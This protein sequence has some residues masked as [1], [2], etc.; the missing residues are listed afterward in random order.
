MV[1]TIAAQV[2]NQIILASE[3]YELSGPIE[4]RIRAAGLP[5][6]EI[7]RVRREALDRLIEGELLSSVVERLELTADREEVDTAIEAI[8]QENGITLEQLINSVQTHG[9]TLDEYRAKI[10]GEI[11]R[12][13]VVN[14]MV[15]SRIQI[16][17]E[18]IEAL[19]KERFSDQRSGGEEILLRHILVMADGPEKRSVADA[20][21]IAAAARTEIVTG[22]ETFPEVARDVSDMNPE[23]GGDLGWMHRKDLA[24]WMAQTVE[25]MQPGEISEVIEMPFGCNLLEVVERR[26]FQPVSFE[27][28][29]PQ[30]QNIIF[31]RKTEAEY[32]KWLDVLR[33]Q[34]YIERKGPFAAGALD[35]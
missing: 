4:D 23:R 13:K 35:G 3:V 25:T 2:G 28:A 29:K 22:T 12:S 31:Q 21:E 14:A 15:R 11:E 20:C 24:A 18:E 6:S 7:A 16:S 5:T 33:A 34:T 27:Q 9:L 8:A 10:Q 32:N 17:D 30:L 19:Y 1:E 26:A